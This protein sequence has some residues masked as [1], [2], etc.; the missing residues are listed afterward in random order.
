VSVEGAIAVTRFGL[1]AREGEIAAASRDPKAWLLAQLIPNASSHAAFDGLLSSPEIYKISRRYKDA[2]KTMGDAEKP[3]SSKTYGNIVRDNFRTEIKARSIYAAQTKAPFHERLTRFWSNHFSV[4]ARNRSTRLFPGAYEREAI[5]PHILGSFYELAASAIFHPAMLTF[6]DNDSSVGPKS[7]QGIKAKKGLNENLA[8]EALELHT[9]TPASGYTQSDV[10]E[11]AKALTGWRI[12]RKT[13]KGRKQGH[14]TFRQERHEPGY[15]TILGKTYK[16]KDAKQALAILKDLCAHPETAENIA[17]KLA[18]HFVSDTPPSALVED[19]KQSYLKSNGNL[20][21]LYKTLVKS[22]LAWA[23]DAHK[24]KT[25]EELIISAS[26]QL[27][28]ENVISKRA[29][30]TYDSLAQHPF[31]A[32]TPE[33]WPDIAEA[34]LGPDAM[35][36]RIEWANELASRLPELDARAFLQ[37]ALGPRLSKHALQSV[38]RAESG[39]Q[40]I[41]LALMSPDFQRR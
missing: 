40:A 28:F 36:K 23:A 30:D 24:M 33:G 29:Q 32:P 8:R 7:R 35:L 38:S 5:R 21:A 6:L 16:E 15:R 17:R 12:E 9:I 1:G 11:F 10:T 26:R 31:T 14:T 22:P 27:G 4:S 39:Q 13:D 20:M 19:L 41:V 37:S 3:G 18:M 2:R 34:W 25:P